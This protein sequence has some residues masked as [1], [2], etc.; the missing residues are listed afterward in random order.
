MVDA[1]VAANPAGL[2]YQPFNYGFNGYSGL[3]WGLAGQNRRNPYTLPAATATQT[4][5][6]TIISVCSK[7]SC[8]ST[9]LFCSYSLNSYRMISICRTSRQT[10][11]T[12]LD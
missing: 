5:I 2:M 7:S 3:P 6:D 4:G 1:S 10:S 8:Y 11:P 12:F 9:Q